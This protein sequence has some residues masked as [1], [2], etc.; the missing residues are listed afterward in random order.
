MTAPAYTL[1]SRCVRCGRPRGEDDV[2]CEFELGER[3]L[4]FLICRACY[5]QAG[6]AEQAEAALRKMLRERVVTG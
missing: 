3:P 2:A 1:L 6:A 5:C 4:I